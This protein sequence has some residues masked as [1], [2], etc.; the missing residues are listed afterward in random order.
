MD[1]KETREVKQEV[2]KYS[3]KQLLQSKKY[4]DRKDVLGVVVKDGENVT[5]EELDKRISTFMKGKVK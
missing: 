2:Q 4:L 3:K 5:L 1:K